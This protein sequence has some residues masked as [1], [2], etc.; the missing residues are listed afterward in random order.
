MSNFILSMNLTSSAITWVPS[1]DL[2]NMC[3]SKI[4]KSI[5]TDSSQKAFLR[6]KTCPME[7]WKSLITDLLGPLGEFK[8]WIGIYFAHIFHTLNLTRMSGNVFTLWMLNLKALLMVWGSR[9]T[10][11][12]PFGFLTKTKLCTQFIAS[13]MC[14]LQ[15]HLALTFCQ[16]LTSKDPTF[17]VDFMWGLYHRF[18]G[19]IHI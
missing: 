12:F 16:A 17:H 11:S 19:Q 8:S 13:F 2:Q 4:G 14:N 9:Q 6:S 7:Y 18:N 1:S 15:I 5:A 10:H 3:P